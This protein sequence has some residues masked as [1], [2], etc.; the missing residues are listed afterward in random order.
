MYEVLEEQTGHQVLNKLDSNAVFRLF[1]EGRQIARLLEP[2]LIQSRLYWSRPSSGLIVGMVVEVQIEVGPEAKRANSM[3]SSAE[4]LTM[5]G[6]IMKDEQNKIY[7][8]LQ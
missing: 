2:V 1:Y 5:A 4:S 7:I 3:L 8:D 6:I